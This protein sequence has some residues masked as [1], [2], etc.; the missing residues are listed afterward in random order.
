MQ[1][2]FYTAAA[3]AILSTLVAISRNNAIHA[4]LYLIIS[5]LSTAL[6][7]YALGAPFIA[8][9]ELITY[10]GA[11]MV[12]FMF[13]VMLLNLGTHAINQ[14]RKWQPF[15]QWVGPVLLCA[16]LFAEFVYAVTG[17]QETRPGFSSISPQ[18]VG[19]RLFS[20]YLLGVEI[21]SMMLLSG[22]VGAFYLGR[23][24]EWTSPTSPVRQK[25]DGGK[26]R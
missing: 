25:R 26:V 1:A 24:I 5:F 20:T 2:L 22:L 21:A 13:A 3:I 6:I 8:A 18:Q 9:L 19:I 16:I 4:I 11:I 14:E 17:T 12:L 23:R 10:A 7:F 15:G